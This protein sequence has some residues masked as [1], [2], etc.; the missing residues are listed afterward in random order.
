MKDHRV[1][2]TVRLREFLDELARDQWSFEN[3]PSVELNSR[4]C[5]GD[6]PLHVAAVRGD[7]QIGRLLIGAGADLNVCGEM[8]LTPLH[9]AISRGY[10]E[11]AKLL[12]AAGARYDI[13]DEWSATAKELAEKSDSPEVR[14]LFMDR[15]H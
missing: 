14:A 8:K 1:N 4:D 7:V 6:T 15:G 3:L 2:D 11:F 9:E 12:L 5:T 13:K 10:V